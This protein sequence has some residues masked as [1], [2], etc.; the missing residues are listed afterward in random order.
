MIR[1]QIAE[2][3]E[4]LEIKLLLDRDPSPVGATGVVATIKPHRHCWIIAKAD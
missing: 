1:E 2:A 4:S 3:V